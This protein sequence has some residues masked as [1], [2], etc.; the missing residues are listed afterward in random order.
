MGSKVK[1]YCIG[2]QGLLA[3]LV[4]VI[5]TPSGTVMLNV[6]LNVWKAG[7]SVCLITYD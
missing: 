4:T 1:G 7:I 3:V 2:I 6:T 5:R